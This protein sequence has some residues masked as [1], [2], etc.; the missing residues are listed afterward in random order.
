MSDQQHASAEVADLPSERISHRGV[1]FDAEALRDFIRWSLRHPAVRDE[2]SERLRD[3]VDG[4]ITTAELTQTL[5]P[6]LEEP[7]A[8]ATEEDWSLVT[9]DFLADAESILGVSWPVL[10]EGDRW[11]TR[12]MEQRLRESTQ[13]AEQLR[14]RARALRDEAELAEMQGIRDAALAL[15]DRYERAADAFA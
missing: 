12:A 10:N 13:S 5:L 1:S 2:L 15:A 4:K 9:A 11:L 7:L 3:H 14:A 6:M 8:A